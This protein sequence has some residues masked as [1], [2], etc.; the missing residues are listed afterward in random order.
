MKLFSAG[1]QLA[2]IKLGEQGCFVGSEDESF[3]CPGFR[4]EAVDTTGAGDSFTAGILYG[5]MHGLGLQATAV[6]AN[7]LGALAST[8]YGAGFS[9][10]EEQKISD[11][12]MSLR[13]N[14]ARELFKPID[15]V[16]KNLQLVNSKY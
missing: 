10:P 12:L 2:A 7:T 15:E 8:V 4:V 6:L 11:F 13:E 3:L 14:S 16:L 1:I 9:F 5:W